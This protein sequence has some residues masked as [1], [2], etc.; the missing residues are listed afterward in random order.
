MILEQELEFGYKDRGCLVIPDTGGELLD[1]ET[2][3]G[4]WTEDTCIAVSAIACGLDEYYMIPS[5]DWAVYTHVHP[6]AK[7]FWC[8]ADK[9]RGRWGVVQLQAVPGTTELRQH[10]PYRDVIMD[11]WREIASRL[12]LGI[13]FMLSSELSAYFLPSVNGA[14]LPKQSVLHANYDQVAKRHGFVYHPDS[15]LFV[16]QDL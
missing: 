15:R 9:V 16:R 8:A 7:S 1:S 14:T 3:I 4:V 12:G 2:A 5:D 6:G 10:L 11:A 13:D